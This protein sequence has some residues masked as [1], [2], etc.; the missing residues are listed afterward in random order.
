[1]KLI[2]ENKFFNDNK[3]VLIVEIRK[4]EKVKKENKLKE[5]DEKNINRS[6]IEL[7]KIIK[8]NE[9]AFKTF[10]TLTFEDSINDIESA[11]KKFNIFRTKIKRIKI[12]NK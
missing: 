4:K 9:K 7:Q 10:I 6:K 5:I 12:K 1:M 8:T 11:N 2:K 3:E